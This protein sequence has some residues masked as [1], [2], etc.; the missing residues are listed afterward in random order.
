PLGTCEAEGVFHVHGAL[1]VVR[2]LFLWVLVQTQVVW[3]HA[4]IDVPLQAVINPVLVPLLILAW[5]DE[6]FHLH[7]LKL[8]S[9]QE[10]VTRGDLIAESLT[11]I[12]DAKRSLHARRG[13][14]IF[15]VY[16]DT[17]CRFGT[18]VVQTFVIIDWAQEAR[19][20][21]RKRLG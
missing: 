11:S 4:Q 18:Q 10:Q 20:Q 14:H 17:L 9:T 5:L 16:E 19:Q 3:I 6:E 13:H 8:T 7:L 12:G 21:T 2:E 15:E 1:G